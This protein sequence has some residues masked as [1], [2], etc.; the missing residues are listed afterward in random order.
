MLFPVLYLALDVFCVTWWHSHLLSQKW[1]NYCQRKKKSLGVCLALQSKGFLGNDGAEAFQTLICVL[2]IK[3]DE[4]DLT[5]LRKK[6]HEFS[7]AGLKRFERLSFR[8]AGSGVYRT[9]VFDARGSALADVH[10]FCVD[11]CGRETCCDGF[12]LNQNVLNGGSIMCGFLTAPTVLQCSES[13]WDV[14]SLSSSSRI[15]GAGVQYSKQLKRFT[16][17]FGGQNFTISM[18]LRPQTHSTVI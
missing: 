15:C 18:S 16:F 8:K 2:K 17:S 3:G 11:S 13:D 14:K 12:I 10:R 6:G 5:V 7:T 4:P 1:H 9:L